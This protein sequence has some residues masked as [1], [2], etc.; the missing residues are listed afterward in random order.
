MNLKVN[1]ICDICGKEFDAKWNHQLYCSNECRE[2]VKSNR[3][4]KT[5]PIKNKTNWSEIGK[6]MQRTGK[7]YGKL[8]QEGII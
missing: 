6:L 4:Q 5:K 2:Y 7:S 3:R 8:V 1:K